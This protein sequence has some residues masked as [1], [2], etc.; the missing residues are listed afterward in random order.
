MITPPAKLAK[1]PCKAKPIASPALV[2]AAAIELVS[3]PT[4]PKND[5][6]D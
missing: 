4:Y 6:R 2:I 3:I 5:S 1:D